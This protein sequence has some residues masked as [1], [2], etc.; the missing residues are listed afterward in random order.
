MIADSQNLPGFRWDDARVLLALL[1]QRTLLAA[2]KSLGVNASTISRR[3]EALEDALGARLFDRTPDGLLPT[4][5]V[6]PLA[7][8]AE[9]MERGAMGLAQAVAGFEREPEGEVRLS[10]PPGVADHLLAGSLVRLQARY[11]RIRLRIDASIGYVDLT[12]REA[13]LALRGLRPASGDLVALKLGHARDVILGSP[14]YA[15]ELGTLRDPK[16]ARWIDWDES[17]SQLPSARWVAKHVPAA[18]VVLRSNSVGTQLAA[19][20]SG[21]GIAWHGLPFTKLPG[22]VEVKV[23]KAFLRDRPPPGGG[24]L[25]LVGHRALR[26]VPRIAVVWDW[27]VEEG[28]RL[29][30]TPS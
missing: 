11:P 16:D 5:A 3:L 27:L 7:V 28:K 18:Q 19:I 17:L 13:D 21:L 23:G 9:A 24:A 12:R 26:D 15:R 4:A 10:A 14:G 29:G 1:R 22:I 2:G 30:L 25:W 8:H 6:E 20:A